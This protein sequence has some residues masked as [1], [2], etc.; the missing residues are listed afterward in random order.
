V[1]KKKIL[2]LAYD[3][4]PYNSIGAQRPYSWI[5]FLPNLGY[6]PIV[7]TRHWDNITNSDDYYLP[8]NCQNTTEEI[9]EGVRIIRTPFRPNLRDKLILKKSKLFIIIRKILSLIYNI[10]QYYS[11]SF[12]NR[13]NLYH[14]ADSLIKKGGI[15]LIIA[16]AEPY[17]LFRYGF[18][19]NKKYNI[20]WIADYRDEWTT[21]SIHLSNRGLQLQFKLFLKSR[22]L[23]FMKSADLIISAANNYSQRLNLFLNQEVKTIYNGYFKDDFKSLIKGLKP[24][25]FEISYIGSLYDYQPLEEFLD[26]VK[27]FINKH[28]PK[29][30]RLVFYGGNFDQ[31]QQKRITEYDPQL[32]EYIVSTDRIPRDILYK[33]LNDQSTAFLILA[34]PKEVRIPGKLFDYMGLGKNIILFKND[35]NILKEIVSDIENGLVCNT[36]FQI[37]EAIEKFYFSEQSITNNQNSTAFTKYTREQQAVELAKLLNNLV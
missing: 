32:S 3:F 14:A 33:R 25:T 16:S 20:P 31:Q 6:E 8:S 28:Q 18:L 1:K 7:I 23:K 11:F 19:L 37:S 22:E 5:K 36:P 9:L 12:D 2:I 15:D 27:I 30:F 24:S 21:D 10:G 26:G 13:S 34:S 35:E 29:N 4:P 17:V